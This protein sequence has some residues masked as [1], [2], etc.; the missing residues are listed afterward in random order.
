MTD[1]E[2]AELQRIVSESV[3]IAVEAALS[4]PRFGWNS[5]GSSWVRARGEGPPDVWGSDPNFPPDL[6][7]R[8]SPDDMQRGA[9][10]PET[11][12]AMKAHR[13]KR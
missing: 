2:K 1:E 11:W 10:S 12:E 8:I 3:A 13:G 5:T 7:T 6:P 9:I 4:K